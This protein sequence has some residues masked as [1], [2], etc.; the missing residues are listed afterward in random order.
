M[1][2]KL[3]EQN[4]YKTSTRRVLAN[5]N[6][7]LN[8][9]YFLSILDGVIVKAEADTKIVWV[10]ETFWEFAEN[11]TEVLKEEV[12]FIPMEAE[13]LYEVDIKWDGVKEISVWKFFNLEDSETVDATSWNT[14][15]GQLELIK[16]ISPSKGI[17][18][19]A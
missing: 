16:Y 9:N 6:L 13:R 10:N 4:G 5:N 8:K 3:Y 11:N 17:F 2:I 7:N 18:K 19:I 12:V 15:N 1:S 14:E